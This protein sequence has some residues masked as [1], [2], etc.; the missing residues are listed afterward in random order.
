[1]RHS[2]ARA[3]GACLAVLA[4]LLLIPTN[5]GAYSVLTHEANID[6]LW[7]SDIVPLLRA[8]F[9]GTS[10]SALESARAYAYGGS[11]IQDLGYYPFGSAFFTNLLHYVKTGDFVEVMLRDARGVD[12]YAF[13][14]GALCH[15]ES[16]AE[17][18]SIAINRALP[19]I[20]PKMRRKYGDSVPYE[21][22]PKEHILTEFAFDVLLVAN[23][24]YKLQAYHDF[25]GFQVS[26]PLLERAFRETYGFD[27]KDLFLSEDL[28]IG[29]YRHS[30]GRL[31]PQATRIAWDQKRDAIM[32]TTPGTVR[33]TFVMTMSAAQYMQDYGRQYR[34]PGLGARIVAFLYR[35]L[36]KIGPLRPL[37]FKVPTPE[38]E[39]LYLESLTR[40]RARFGEALRELRAGHLH[41]ANIDLDTGKPSAPGEYALADATMKH[42]ET[43][44]R[45]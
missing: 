44:T 23:G 43:L 27:M 11:V 45:K 8:R 22:A 19:L 31:I 42:L 18:H 9:P 30:V 32:K 25:I 21:K 3:V 16:D 35:L 39:R 26:K 41:L 28:A 1:M 33:D 40:S 34:R 38:A 4:T 10:A 12:E 36:P 13:A 7:A 2:R 17:G 14:I 24:G 5:A 37:A 15:Y 20:Y 29:T 6:A